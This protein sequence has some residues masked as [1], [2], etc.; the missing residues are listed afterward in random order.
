MPPPPRGTVALWSLVVPPP[1]R[2]EGWL[3]A[4]SDE[5]A[6]RAGRFRF[7]ADRAA[8]V[9]AHAL[10]RA[11]LAAHGVGR[12]CF[13]AG[14]WGKPELVDAPGGLRFSL[15]HTRGLVVA[16]VAAGDDLGVDAE[17]ADRE[18][19]AVGLA[20]RF[21]APAEAAAIAAT[22]AAGR[23]EAFLRLWTL[24]EAFAKAVGQGLSLPLSSFAFG[25][26]SFTCDPAQGPA[27]GW[28]FLSR[29][30]QSPAGHLAVA[31][32]WPAVDGLRVEERAL[33]PAALDEAL[34][35]GGDRQG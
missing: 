1:P 25:P 6:A 26:G 35:R 5:E 3:P 20:A 22:P 8:Y 30:V 12:P 19:D 7:A 16:G 15:S 28:S 21:F 14:P 34:A 32:R 18:V 10:L 29:P 13:R 27:D 33:S 17:L 31:L 4:L 9:A 23:M 11:L 2:A 24:K